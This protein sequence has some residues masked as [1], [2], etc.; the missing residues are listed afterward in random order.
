VTRH[1]PRRQPARRTL[2][3]DGT[4]PQSA[5]KRRKLNTATTTEGL[6]GVVGQVFCVSSTL[7]TGPNQY[8]A[9]WP[10]MIFPKR[11]PTRSSSTQTPSQGNRPGASAD[12]QTNALSEMCSELLRGQ[13]TLISTLCQRVNSDSDMNQLLNYHRELDMYYQNMISHAQVC[14]CSR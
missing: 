12:P 13:N 8:G 7:V 6:E 5:D 14:P 2:S 10:G 4:S 11:Q 3:E 9:M 1:T